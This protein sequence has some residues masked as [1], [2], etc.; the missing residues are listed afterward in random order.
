MKKK[1][2]QTKQSKCDEKVIKISNDFEPLLDHSALREHNVHATSLRSNKSVDTEY[3][4]TVDNENKNA[5][6]KVAGLKVNLHIIEACNMHCEFCFAKFKCKKSLSFEDWKQ[7]VDNI[8]A[9]NDRMCEGG[10]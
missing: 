4:R 10:K 3:I 1:D 2:M 8:V 5:A 7:I 9:Y 6:S